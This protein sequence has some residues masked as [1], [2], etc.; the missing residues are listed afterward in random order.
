MK[1][2]DFNIPIYDV[3]VTLIQVERCTESECR[4]VRKVLRDLGCPK[5]CVDEEISQIREWST[6]GGS[7]CTNMTC[8]KMVV[9]FQELTSVERLIEVYSHEKRH[10]E[11]RILEFFNVEDHESSALLAGYVGVEFY[12]FF[13]ETVKKFV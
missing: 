6:N 10:I 1:R 11:D 9:L 7:T 3:D 5:E 2:Y 4:K 8:R 13:G 12:K